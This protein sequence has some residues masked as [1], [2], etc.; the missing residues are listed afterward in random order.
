MWVC[1]YIYNKYNF[2]HKSARPSIPQLNNPCFWH[3][4]NLLPPDPRRI[5]RMLSMSIQK[6][7]TKKYKIEVIK[8][9][10]RTTTRRLVNKPANHKPLNSLQKRSSSI[11]DPCDTEK[12]LS[13]KPRMLP[14]THPLCPKHYSTHII[15]QS[16]C[17]DSIIYHSTWPCPSA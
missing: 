9:R 8:K 10:D 14:S 5:E 13:A 3:C 11:L 16:N 12:D 7:E 6:K 17:I 1:F 15:H 2:K 4:S